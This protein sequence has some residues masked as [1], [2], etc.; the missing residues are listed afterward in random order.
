MGDRMPTVRCKSRLTE[1]RILPGGPPPIAA[2][3]SHGR[4]ELLLL[5]AR[6]SDEIDAVFQ[7]LGVCRVPSNHNGSRSAIHKK[8]TTCPE[9]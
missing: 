7:E 2:P 5:L 4:N 3:S 8:E 6:L 9:K 1:S